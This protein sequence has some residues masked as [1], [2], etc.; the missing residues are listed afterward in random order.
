ME[1]Q[2][3]KPISGMDKNINSQRGNAAKKSIKEKKYERLCAFVENWDEIDTK[4]NHTLY[5]TIAEAVEYFKSDKG[6]S[7]D[8]I[9]RW[10]EEF[11]ELEIRD[12]A[13]VLVDNESQTP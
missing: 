12:S 1:L 6:F 9:K 13:L 10:V 11:D 3:A 8:S 2:D 7:R 4:K 5:P